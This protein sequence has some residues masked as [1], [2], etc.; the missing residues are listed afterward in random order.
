MPTVGPSESPIARRA[1]APSLSPTTALLVMILVASVV[2]ADELQGKS[3]ESPFAHD[4]PKI[5]SNGPRMLSTTRSTPPS[6]S[7]SQP[8][9]R[10]NMHARLSNFYFFGT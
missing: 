4:D 6:N 3:R 9:R 1:N 2:I 5:V 10:V 8:N 7:H